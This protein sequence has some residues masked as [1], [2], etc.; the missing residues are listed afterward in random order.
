M[1]ALFANQCVCY[2]S[3]QHDVRSFELEQQIDS[4]SSKTEL[5]LRVEADKPVCIVVPSLVLN[6]TTNYMRL[7]V[8]VGG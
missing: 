3:S 1:I 8:V 2:F 4:Y 6:N 7:R 5:H